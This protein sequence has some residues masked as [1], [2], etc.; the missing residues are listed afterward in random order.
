M[1]IHEAIANAI[2][3]IEPIAKTRNN[4][5]QNFMFRGIDDIMNTL[6][7]IL[8]KNRIF[9]YPEVLSKEREERHTAKGGNLIYSILT[10]KYHF[11][12]DDGSEICAVVIGEGMDSGDKASNKALA[13]AYKYACLQVFCIPTRDIMDSDNETPP[14]STKKPANNTTGNEALI[15][16][17]KALITE[18]QS[19]MERKNAQGIPIFTDEERARCKSFTDSTGPY[20]QGIKILEERRNLLVQT[21]LK[22]AETPTSKNSVAQPTRSSSR[23]A[24]PVSSRSVPSDD[25][26]TDDIPF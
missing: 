16:K 13:V 3:D 8:S 21:A 5:A 25:G 15:E 9:I 23:R 22:R 2:S 17:R 24:E 14:D 26:F 20:E 10:V 18:I 12:T 11:A 1:K 6:N 7:P 4:S 19:I